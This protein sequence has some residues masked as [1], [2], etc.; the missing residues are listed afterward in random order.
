MPTN[1]ARKESRHQRILDAALNVFSRQG[2]HEAAVDEIATLAD[3]SKGGLYF[4]FPGKQSIFLALLDRSA[5]LL[6]TRIVERMEE[7]S[8]PIAKVDA[9]LSALMHV[10]SA[11]RSL[12]RLLLLEA[13]GAG[14]EFHAKLMETHARFARFITESLDEAVAMGVL[15]PLDTRVAGIAWFGALNQVITT[16]ILTDEPGDLDA[17]YPAL[18]SLL[19]HGVGLKMEAET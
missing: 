3:T 10:F 9:A 8:D 17:T 19:L 1:H 11:H 7:T 18:R 15:A 16:W 5:D 4:H 13:Q 12:A 14:P 2:Y 6:L